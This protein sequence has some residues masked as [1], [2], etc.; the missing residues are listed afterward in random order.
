V[1]EWATLETT[2]HQD[3]VI[4]H[5]IGTTVLGYFVRDETAYLLLDIGFIWRTYLDGE[6][7][8]LPHPVAIAEL[9]VDQAT[10]NLLSADIDFLLREG[11]CA[12]GLELITAVAG[13]SLLRS[14]EFFARENS[15]RLVL[16]CDDG[17]IVM[18]TSLDNGELTIMCSDKDSVDGV[19]GEEGL[20]GAVRAEQAFVRQRL[21]AELG[22]EPTAEE[23]N[24]WL[25]EQTEGY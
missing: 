2:T 12:I 9:E 10:K 19:N 4:A 24:E 15:R 22:R 3:H 1:T 11:T 6:M 8:L 14:V 13:E 7:G 21:R 18:E 23:M 20:G 5:V 17:K 16:T 25:R